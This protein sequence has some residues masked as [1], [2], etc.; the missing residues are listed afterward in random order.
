MRK[1]KIL[2]LK[3]AKNISPFGYAEMLRNL[4]DL[5]SLGRCDSFG[6]VITT[7]FHKCSVYKRSVGT[8]PTVLAL[9]KVDCSGPISDYEL[10]LIANHCPKMRN[11]RLVYNPVVHRGSESQSE[12]PDLAVLSKISNLD[13]IGIMSAD[14]YSHSLFTVIETAGSRLTHLE[15]TNVDELNLAGLMMIGDHCKLVTH[16]S[17][18]CCHYT[19]EQSDRIRLEQACT[20]QVGREKRKM[21]HLK[22]YFR[23]GYRTEDHFQN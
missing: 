17:I 23:P 13:E 9:A 11:L 15:L 16:L 12:L 6:E 20:P 7:L 8:I 5:C 2:Q 1:L 19:P 3:E 14:F 4:P 18:C 22:T 21:L 10:H